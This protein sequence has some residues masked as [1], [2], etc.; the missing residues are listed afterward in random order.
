MRISQLMLRVSLVAL[1]CAPVA[2]SASAQTTAVTPGSLRSYSTIA[3]IGVE[4]DLTG[5]ANHDATATLEYRKVGTSTWK[6]NTSTAS[7][8]RCFAS[9]SSQRASR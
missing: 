1:F 4:W 6:A 8:R 7:R 5:D 2:T 9:L 3:S